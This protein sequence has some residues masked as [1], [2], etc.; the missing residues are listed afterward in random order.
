MSYEEA[1]EA[2]V[3]RAEAKAEIERHGGDG[4]DVFVADHGDHTEY[5]GDTVLGW[6]GY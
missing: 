3:S 5:S 6:L 2:T 1:V 4:W